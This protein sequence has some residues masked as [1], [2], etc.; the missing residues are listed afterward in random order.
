MKICS[1]KYFVYLGFKKGVFM[2]KILST[3]AIITISTS[4]AMAAEQQSLSSFLNKQVSKIEQKE[5]D[6]NDKIEYQKKMQ[7]SKKV[8]VQKK[9]Q[10]Q[11]DA[12]DK[13]MLEAKKQEQKHREA[14]EAKKTEAQKL[15]EEQIKAA[16]RAK[17]EAQRRNEARAKQIEEHANNWKNLL[18]IQ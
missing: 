8:E 11:L 13:K 5:K 18:N 3:L 12:I 4:I 2:K 16:E 15:K 1:L 17:Q 6:F 7:E 14:I 9:Q 10:A